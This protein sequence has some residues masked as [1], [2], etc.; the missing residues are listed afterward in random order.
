MN[1]KK[2]VAM[3]W[4]RG[5]VKTMKPQQIKGARQTLGLSQTKMAELCGLT[6]IGTWIK[7]EKGTRT[8]GAIA[9]Q[10]IK[11]LLWL[12]RIGKLDEWQRQI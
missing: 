1:L 10:H 6:S 4:T 9:V 3:Q 7:W 12:H 5:L 8:P 11:I 2:V